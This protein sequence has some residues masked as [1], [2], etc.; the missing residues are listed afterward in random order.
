MPMY[1]IAET[2]KLFALLLCLTSSLYDV[3]RISRIW[4]EML[5]KGLQRKPE[6]MKENEMLVV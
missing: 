2:M 5:A 3:Q 4:A 1:I 6:G